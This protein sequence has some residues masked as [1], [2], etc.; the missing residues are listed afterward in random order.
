M[1]SP[2]QRAKTRRGT[3]D[4]F[5]CYAVK[6]GR[7]IGIFKTWKETHESVTGY[8]GC[9]FQGFTNENEAK[10]FLGNDNA[11]IDSSLNNPS[12]SGYS[13]HDLKNNPKTNYI[14][15]PCGSQ[16]Q[17]LVDEMIGI[18]DPKNSKPRHE[19][20]NEPPNGMFDT[21]NST[22]LSSTLIEQFLKRP[23]LG[24]HL[25]FGFYPRPADLEPPP[26]PFFCFL[27]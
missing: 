22:F 9:L 6:K 14:N 10:M 4:R 1:P 12:T 2:Q 11:I 7:S 5:T 19:E 20:S 8:A 23:P 27:Y 3:R 16:T 24:L 15:G 17:L 13:E 21:A 25:H 18:K 26:L